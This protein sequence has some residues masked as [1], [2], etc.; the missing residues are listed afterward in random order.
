M[1]D[2]C[3]LGGGAAGLVAAASLDGSLKKCIVEKNEIPGRKLMATG[4]GR[5]NITNAACGGKAVTLDFFKSI[6]HRNV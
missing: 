1:Y 4:G 5:C 6:R 3:I 2:V